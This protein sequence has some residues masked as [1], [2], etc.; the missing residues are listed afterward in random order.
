M[1]ILMIGDIVGNP[2][3]RILKE[4]LSR[5]RQELGVSAV[6]VNAENAAAGSGITVALAQE[7]T[8]VGVDAITMG[9]HTWG[10]KEFAPTIGQLQN[11]VRPANFPPEAPGKGWQLITT[12]ICRFAVLNLLGRVFMQPA[13]CPFHAADAALREI[14]K[15]SDGSACLPLRAWGLLP[16]SPVGPLLTATKA[17]PASWQQLG[18][19]APIQATASLPH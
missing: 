8:A 9:D 19:L 7:I 1:K 12:P 4:R 15:E 6:I 10:Q 5:V 2:G 17:T 16:P 14:P 3:R 11:L 13:D 18:L